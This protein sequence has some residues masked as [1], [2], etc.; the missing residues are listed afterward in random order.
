MQT[1]RIGGSPIRAISRP[2]DPPAAQVGRREVVQ[3]LAAAL[4]GVPLAA[5]LAEDEAASALTPEAFG[6]KGDGTTDDT[7]AFM[8]LSAAIQARGGGDVQLRRNAFYLVGRRV[9]DRRFYLTGV[10]ILAVSGVPRFVV[11]MN[12]ATLKLRSGLKFGTFDPA[13]GAPRQVRL[14]F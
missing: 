8:R 11:R 4:C 14:P 7:T 10:P 3:G 9:P 12:G 1:M 6:A 5:A 2:S 13:S